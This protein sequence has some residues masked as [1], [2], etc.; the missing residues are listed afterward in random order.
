[1]E[2]GNICIIIG[3]SMGDRVSQLFRNTSED[4][5]RANRGITLHVPS[6]LVNSQNHRLVANDSERGN[7]VYGA[8]SE[9]LCMMLRKHSYRK[10]YLC[11]TY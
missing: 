10:S 2:L 3:L 6:N 9:S 4:S 8:E 5:L 11:L 1:M 7:P